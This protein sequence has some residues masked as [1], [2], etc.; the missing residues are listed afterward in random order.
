MRFH[1][2]TGNFTVFRSIVMLK[3]HEAGRSTVRIP[4]AKNENRTDN[5]QYWPLSLFFPHHEGHLTHHYT[6]LLKTLAAYGAYYLRKAIKSTQ[7]FE[8]NFTMKRVWGL[9]K[10]YNTCM[11][12][13]CDCRYDHIKRNNIQCSQFDQVSVQWIIILPTDLIITSHYG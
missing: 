5:P 12:G 8:V 3:S 7:F 1:G 2:D 10:Y 4:V 11:D 6:Y 13:I 9:Q